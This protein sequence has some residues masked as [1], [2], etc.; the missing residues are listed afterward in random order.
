MLVDEVVRE[1]ARRG[2]GNLDRCKVIEKLAEASGEIELL[3]C[4]SFQLAR[5]KTSVF[6]SN[7]LP[8]VTSRIC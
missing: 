2:G 5:R 6:E 3:S 7:G 1:V 8:F 4:R